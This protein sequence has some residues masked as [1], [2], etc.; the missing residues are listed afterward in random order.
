MRILIATLLALGALSARAETLYVTDKLYLGVYSEKDKGQFTSITSGTALEVIAQERNWVHAR[1]PDGREGWVKSKYLVDK[2]PAVVRLAELEQQLEANGDTATSSVELD[3]LRAEKASLEDRL[4]GSVQEASVLKEQLST[5]ESAL[6][7]AEAQLA[8]A[9]TEAP[10][11]ASGSEAP[12]AVDEQLQQAKAQSD[13][14]LQAL[15]DEHEALKQHEAELTQRLADSEARVSGALAALGGAVQ[16][17]APVEAPIRASAAAVE[18]GSPSDFLV[19]L[20]LHRHIHALYIALAFASM[21]IG[22]WLGIRWLDRR[23]RARHGGMR[24]W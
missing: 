3:G 21:A 24:L 15:R 17:A 9:K 22:F 5:A 23:I 6:A 14:A 20:G 16:A 8:A 2:A 11:E 7:A 19:R 13:A 10:V 1:L 12:A 18:T 4:E